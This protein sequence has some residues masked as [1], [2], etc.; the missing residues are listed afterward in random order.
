[1]SVKGVDNYTHNNKGDFKYL[2][3]KKKKENRSSF[4]SVLS[5]YRYLPRST[6]M[7]RCAVFI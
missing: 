3:F 2:Y 4:Y 1:M 5:K 6:D 7:K